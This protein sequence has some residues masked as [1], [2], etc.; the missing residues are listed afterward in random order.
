MRNINAD[1]V[2]I[3]ENHVELGE[4]IRIQYDSLDD[5]IGILSAVKEARLRKRNVVYYQDHIG[6]LISRAEHHTCNYMRV[7]YSYDKN[8]MNSL[9]SIDNMNEVTSIVYPK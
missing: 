9:I 3:F 8:L 2:N 5:I 4:N 7:Y 6:V 1:D